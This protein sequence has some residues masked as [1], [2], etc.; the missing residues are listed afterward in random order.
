[1]S[2]PATLPY[3]VLASLLYAEFSWIERSAPLVVIPTKK[4]C[5]QLGTAPRELRQALEWLEVGG[6][7][8]KFKWC[9]HYANVYL[10]PP[11]GM[12]LIVNERIAGSKTDEETATS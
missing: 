5:L 11:Q 6:L 1:M 4:F 12:G 9:G 8:S 2:R 3:R 10:R 7:I